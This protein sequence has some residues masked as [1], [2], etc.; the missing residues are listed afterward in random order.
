MS[1]KFPSSGWCTGPDS[2]SENGRKPTELMMSSTK[3]WKAKTS[4]FFQCN[5]EDLLHLLW[6]WTAF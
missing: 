3:I 2:L 4:Y 5:L 1:Q 6:V